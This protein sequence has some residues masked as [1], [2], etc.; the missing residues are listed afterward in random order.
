MRVLVIILVVINFLIK[1]SM[2]Q[3]VMELKSEKISLDSAKRLIN[4]HSGILNRKLSITPSL[5]VYE[6]NDNWVISIN[7]NLKAAHLFTDGYNALKEFDASR[8]RS[9]FEN[10]E[11]EME[12]FPLNKDSILKNLALEL[13]IQLQFTF[14]NETFSADLQSRVDRYTLKRGRERLFLG[15]VTL[16]E[17]DVDK[18]IRR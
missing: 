1:P 9:I 5:E 7:P 8:P 3:N 18:G 12:R 10:Y 14:D 15:L 13:D 11:A 4:E 2:A 17:R 16:M 6:L